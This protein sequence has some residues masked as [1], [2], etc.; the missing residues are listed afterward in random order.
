MMLEGDGKVMLLCGG[1]GKDEHFFERQV[2][3]YGSDG[4][5]VT[6]HIWTPWFAA[7]PTTIRKR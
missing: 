6:S 7:S 5:M 4:V 2:L 1:P 3:W